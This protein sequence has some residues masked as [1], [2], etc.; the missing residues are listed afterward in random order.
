MLTKNFITFTRKDDI[1]DE[2]LG[3]GGGEG[4]VRKTNIEGGLA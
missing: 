3:R 2:K 1:K 4:L